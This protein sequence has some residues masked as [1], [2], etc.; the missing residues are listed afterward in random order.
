MKKPFCLY[1]KNQARVEYNDYA[2]CCWITKKFNI[3]SNTQDEFNEYQNWLGQIDD[4]VPE[5]NF[6]QEKE[7]R[8][9]ISPRQIAEK[10]PSIVGITNV[11]E[12]N[13]V[14]S[15]E[16]QIDTNCNAACLICGDYNSTTWQKYSSSNAVNK[17]VINKQ[18]DIIADV[19]ATNRYNNIFKFVSL[20]DINLVVFLGGEP[21]LSEFH[22]QTLKD[23]QKSKPL[24]QVSVRYV[25]NGSQKPDA[26]TIELWKQLK[27]LQ[28]SFSIDGIGK[29]FN[30][31]RW[32][33]QWD[34]VENN[35]KY[36]INLNIPDIKLEISSAINPLNIFY[37]DQYME[38]EKTIFPPRK[39]S[40]DLRFLQ[41]FDT[42]GI[43]NTS[44]IPPNLMEEIKTKYANDPWLVN[45]MRPFDKDKFNAFI[46]YIEFHDKK[47]KLNWKET[48]PEIVKYFTDI[49]S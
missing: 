16:F 48:F 49:I 28:I 46:Q 45:R 26:E 23:I 20:N 37:Y 6:C 17:S 24:D 8:N 33:L 30:Y 12:I 14:T 36:I 10:K 38:W 13:K 43:I 34:Q 40:N 35:I 1:L 11:L 32:P 3:M 42:N 27:T 15:L 25:T 31:L 39:S 7:S 5:C 41:G 47:R 22:K 21:L 9:V 18:I 29:H 2:P 4:W 19:N 44:S